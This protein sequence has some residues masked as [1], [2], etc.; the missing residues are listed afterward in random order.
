[1]R[2]TL[3]N[4]ILIVHFQGD[5]E[6]MNALLNP[7]SNQYEGI[8]EHREGHNFPSVHIPKEHFLAKYKPMCKYVIG[9]YNTKSIAHELLHAKFYMDISYREQILLEW[10]DLESAHRNIITTFLKKLGYSEK[11]LI[12]EYQAYRYTEAP[13]FFGIRLSNTVS[14]SNRAIRH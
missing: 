14:E 6:H 11:V 10:Q 1:M 9:C 3:K 5:K 4:A 8:L 2:I 12:D 13:N 7:I